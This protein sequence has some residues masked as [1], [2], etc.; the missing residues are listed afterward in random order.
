LRRRRLEQL[1]DTLQ[2]RVR[3]LLE[4][5]ANPTAGIIDSQSVKIVG[6]ISFSGF[7][8]AKKVDRRKRH[9]VTDAL[10]LLLFVTVHEASLADRASAEMV[11][12]KV[13]AKVRTL[14]TIFADQE[15]TGVLIERMHT[16]LLLTI[17]IIKRTEH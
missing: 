14:M 15:Y 17:E 8:G 4:R 10:G 1:N 11:L 5:D 6:N 9:I 3:I 7:D 12:T 16:V 2:K 13:K